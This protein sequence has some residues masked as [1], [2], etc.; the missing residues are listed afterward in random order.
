MSNE[1]VLSLLEA[2]ELY[3]Q[4]M[5]EVQALLSEGFIELSNTRR[6]YPFFYHNLIPL[7]TDCR[8]VYLNGQ[9]IDEEIDIPNMKL[10]SSSEVAKIRNSFEKVLKQVLISN[11]KMIEVKL[12][13]DRLESEMQGDVH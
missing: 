3:M 12:L 11:K 1:D 4:S 2:T 6:Y 5:S 8:K 10:V 9:E 13:C 7:D